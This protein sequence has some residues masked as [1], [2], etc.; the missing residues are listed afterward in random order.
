M[1]CR[2]L[3]GDNFG[4]KEAAKALGSGV[5]NRVVDCGHGDDLLAAEWAC[6]G[7]KKEFSVSCLPLFLEEPRAL[8]RPL[9]VLIFF[10]VI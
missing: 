3:K 1:V 10:A 5:F 7:E 4:T 8:A 2:S 9:G 6:G